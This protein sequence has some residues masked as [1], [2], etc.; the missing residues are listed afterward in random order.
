M[1]VLMTV[2]PVL[3]AM[4]RNRPGLVLVVFQIGLTLAI[5]CNAL[6]VIGQ[7]LE[8]TRTPSGVDESSLFAIQSVWTGSRNVLE[9]RIRSDVAELRSLP[10]VVDAYVTNS[11]PFANGGIVYGLV[12]HPDGKPTRAG[13]AAYFGDEHTL[14]TLGLKLVAGRNFNASDIVNFDGSDE[15]PA[16]SGIIVSRTLA[17]RLAPAGLKIGELVTVDPM[18]KA[19]IIGIIER[20][21]G[22]WAAG[23]G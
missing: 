10:D 19:P 6:S 9:A 12:L 21:Q 22:P 11:Y 17:D 16:T 15:R 3:V 4:R 20:L 18:G 14:R 7:R 2:S 1:S 23:S 13:G 8:P 5:V